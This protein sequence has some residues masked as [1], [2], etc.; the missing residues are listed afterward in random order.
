MHLEGLKR[1]VDLRGGLNAIRNTNPMAANLVFW[2]A[3]ISINEPTLLPLTYGDDHLEIDWLHD[4]DTAT[5]LTHDGGQA[6]LIE[7]G[8]DVVTANIL[9]EVQHLSMLY[10][11]TLAYNTPQDAIT[12]LSYLCSILERL[13]RMSSSPSSDSPV[14]GLSQSCRLAG[15]LHVFTPMSG[16]FPNP[17][18]M[19]QTLV[20][21]L[22]SSLTHM[23]HA[24]G[25]QSSLLLWLLAVGGITAHAMPER[26]WFVG[27]LVVVVT[28][29]G[30][31]SWD[32]MRQYL[33][34]LA[35]HDNFC[36]VSFNALWN[37]VKQKQ[38]ILNPVLEETN[39][40][41]TMGWC[42]ELISQVSQA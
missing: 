30:I 21:D 10:T 33:V 11:S 37:E 24:V 18:L 15:C 28:D 32:A 8:V 27:H 12:V 16:Y 4:V 23:M 13:L 25:T 29:L 41:R 40:P 3:M 36:D 5:L 17:T 38:A 26:A 35:F 2:C 34:K 9:H 7:F 14:P 22:K 6:D 42:E 20:R 31:Q 19:L 1:V 39:S